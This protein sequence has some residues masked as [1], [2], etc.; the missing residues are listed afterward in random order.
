MNKLDEIC[1]NTTG[2]WMRQLA[3]V[4]DKKDAQIQE[5]SR[6]INRLTQNRVVVGWLHPHSKR[7]V[8]A[9]SK[10]Y[11]LKSTGSKTYI[12]HRAYTVPVFIDLE[13]PKE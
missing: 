5:Q 6:V 2:D 10:E 9:D 3:K 11:A 8:Y 12:E 4:I 7:V 1:E 13:V